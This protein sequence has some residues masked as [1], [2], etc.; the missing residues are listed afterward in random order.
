MFLYG[1]IN[2]GLRKWARKCSL[3]SC[4][5]RE[6]A[7][8]WC[9]SFL[10]FWWTSPV[11]PS[12]PGVF[13]DSQ[14][15]IIDW[16]SLRNKGLFKLFFL[17]TWVLVNSHPSLFLVTSFGLRSTLSEINVAAPASLWWVSAGYVYLVFE[18]VSWGS[19]HRW[20]FCLDLQCLFIGACGLL[21]Q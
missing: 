3:C 16:I 8:G 17:F 11:G 5:L 21:A 4:V 1:F 20:F 15:L 10:K 14:L 7:E 2:V 6:T 9:N 13:C 18:G 19:L 12:G